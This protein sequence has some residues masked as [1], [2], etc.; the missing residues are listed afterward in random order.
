MQISSMKYKQTESDRT[1]KD[2]RHDRV[3]F[4]PGM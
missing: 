2:M 1:L 3:S 4:T